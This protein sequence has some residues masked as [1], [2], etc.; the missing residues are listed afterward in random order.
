MDKNKARELILHNRKM[1]DIVALNYDEKH[2]EIFNPTEQRRIRQ[3]LQHAIAEIKTGSL[4]PMVLDFGAG[5]GNLTRHLLDLQ[6]NVVAA[7]VSQG[8]IYQ[9]NIKMGSSNKLQTIIL[10]GEDLSN[11]KDSVFDMVATYS[12][13]HHIP[14]YLKIVDEFVRVIKPGGIIYIDHEVCPAY[15]EEDAIYQAYLEELGGRFSQDHLYELGVT[16]GKM[17][18]WKVL[19]DSLYS[20]VRRMVTKNALSEQLSDD[21]GDIHVY[22]HDHIEWGDIE[23]RLIQ[24]CDIIVKSDYLVC[25]EFGDPPLVCGKWRDKCVDMRMIIAR[26]SLEKL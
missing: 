3:V 14:D 16:Q 13:L 17:K 4:V 7:D 9:L 2:K 11:M 26:K 23:S 5:T 19:I 6:A 10:N 20:Y 21:Y 15:W 18:L 24:S 12:V 1:H 22:K 25:R 8:C